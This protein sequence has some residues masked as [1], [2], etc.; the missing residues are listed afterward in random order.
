[1]PTAL[2]VDNDQELR[3]FLKDV[4]QAEG[5]TVEVAENGHE[6]FENLRSHPAPDLMVTDVRMPVMSGLELLEAMKKARVAPKMPVIVQTGE[7]NLKLPFKCQVL[8]KPYDRQA[9]LRAIAH[10]QR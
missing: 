1:M 4:L 10:A 6:A 9:L 2:I 7:D 8:R 3:D 5:Y